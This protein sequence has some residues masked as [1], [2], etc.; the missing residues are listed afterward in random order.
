MS[1]A[2]GQGGVATAGADG[3]NSRGKSASGADEDDEFLGA[4]NGGVEQVALPPG[5]IF[6]WWARR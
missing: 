3:A 4:G 1:R 6:V 5:A 2:V